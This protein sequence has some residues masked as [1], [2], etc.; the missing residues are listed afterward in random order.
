MNAIFTAIF[1]LSAAILAFTA[2]QNFLTV[3][4]NGAKESLTVAVTLFCI[5]AVWM[6]IAAVAEKCG[7]TS[8][9]AKLLKPFCSRFFKTQNGEVCGAIAMN[10]TCNLLGVGAS[11][12]YAVKAINGLAKENNSYAQNLLFVINATGIQLIPSTVIALR[13][14]AGSTSSADIFLPCLICSVI[15]TAVAVVLFVSSE[16]LFAERRK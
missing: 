2:P 11:T 5:Y 8:K 14:Q 13:T 12:P 1:I 15:A 9:A 6:G 3:L 16:K 7:I 4:L 10:L